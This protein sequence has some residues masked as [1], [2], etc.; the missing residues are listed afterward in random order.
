MLTAPATVASSG[1]AVDVQ[2]AA[3]H[4]Y[5]S[6][7]RTKVLIELESVFSGRNSQH[8]V[9]VTKGGTVEASISASPSP[10]TEGNPLT[11]SVTL[12]YPLNT[13][14]DKVIPV[15]VSQNTAEQG[16][17]YFS[18]PP[19]VL[20]RRGQTTGTTT[21]QTVHDDDTDDEVIH[22]VLGTPPSGITPGLTIS[23]VT[24]TDTGG[25][26]SDSGSG[27]SELGT[28]CPGCSTES[29]GGTQAPGKTLIEQMR[30]WRN[31]PQWV[32]YKSHTDR[33][34]R[35][36]KA[37][38][39]TVADNSLTPMTAAEAKAFADSGMTRWVD[40]ATALQAREL[41]ETGGIDPVIGQP[42]PSLQLVPPAL[43]GD[44]ITQMYGWRE[45]PNWRTYKAHT[46]RWD[47][48]LHFLRRAGI[49]HDA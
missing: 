10:V 41:R 25:S 21:I 16:D 42:V 38:G 2:L 19:N 7:Y 13:K 36:L 27:I 1:N 32:S 31:D 23:T 28:N 44:L 45:D 47:R 15:S 18:S 9:I 48:A 5:V 30:E 46:D 3:G 17:Y 4:Q 14:S 24:I 40:V 6:E 43:H 49:G 37:L 35:A 34:D 12:N 39:E 11:V 20:I 8:T 26:G 22:V 29:S 33:W